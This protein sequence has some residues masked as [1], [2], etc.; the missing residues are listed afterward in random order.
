MYG[1][2]IQDNPD[3]ELFLLYLARLG[4]LSESPMLG[5][6]AYQSISCIDFKALSSNTKLQLFRE[7]GI[8]ASCLDH[9]SK[10]YR[11]D[12]PRYPDTHTDYSLP[13]VDL[14]GLSVEEVLHH[15]EHL[16]N[17]I[18]RLKKMRRELHKEMKGSLR[19]QV[20]FAAALGTT[21]VPT[22]G[23]SL[24]D[25]TVECNQAIVAHNKLLGTIEKKVKAFLLQHK[26]NP[27]LVYQS[28]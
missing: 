13:A 15:R 19:A 1:G 6:H 23:Y 2:G 5:H 4:Q 21:T 27:P 20:Y 10:L 26:A 17:K 8:H 28:R 24:M 11:K 12:D 7:L 18:L 14:E 22:V 9:V 16:T 25:N 3:K